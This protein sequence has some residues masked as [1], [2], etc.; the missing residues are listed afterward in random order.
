MRV[1]IS[2]SQLSRGVD[3]CPTVFGEPW[4]VAKTSKLPLNVASR[5]RIETFC[6]S[7][8]VRTFAGATTLCMTLVRHAMGMRALAFMAGWVSGLVSVTGLQ[9]H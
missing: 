1:A 7:E 8:A 2:D 4:C 5:K 3:G 9:S 6:G